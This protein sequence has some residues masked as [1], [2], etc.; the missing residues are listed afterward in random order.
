METSGVTPAAQERGFT[1][2]ELTL[3]IVL[4]GILSVTTVSFIGDSAVG[5]ASTV[6]RTELATTARLMTER[7][8]RDLRDALP[9]SV[10]V[11]GNCIEFV[12]VVAASSYLYLPVTESTTTFAVVPLETG[13]V[14][15]SDRV[16][17]FPDSTTQIYTLTAHGPI[18]DTVSF[19]VPDGDNVVT[20]TLSVSHQFASES[21]RKRFYVV[22]T[23][24]SYCLDTQRMWRYSSYG[25]I[26]SQPTGGVLPG[27]MP[28]RD[29]VAFAANRFDSGRRD[30]TRRNRHSHK[31]DGQAQA[32]PDRK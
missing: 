12:P 20:A 7:F 14:N 23:P 8:A 32:Q 25:Y 1:L 21:P 15:G 10:R 30:N 18:S 11:S 6:R 5:Y 26:A 22:S 3:V 16:A 13:Y 9:N 17:V 2:V 28:G 24:V 31:Q 29:L 19:S 4:M 27:S